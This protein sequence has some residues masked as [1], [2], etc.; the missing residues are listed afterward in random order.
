MLL[1][2]AEKLAG[3]NC[4]IGNMVYWNQAVSLAARFLQVKILLLF[5]PDS[6]YFTSQ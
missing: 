2:S 3:V 5:M 6:I 1:V 4:I